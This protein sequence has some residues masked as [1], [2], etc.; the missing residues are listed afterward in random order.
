MSAPPG[1]EN[2]S[3]GRPLSPS[4]I[5][6]PR[7]SNGWDG[8]QRVGPK[9]A[10]LANPEALSDPDYSDEDAP[11]V[12]QIKADEDLLEDYPLDTEDIDLVHC[13]IMSMPDLH[14]ER[15]TK[16]QR[17]C[18]RQNQ[19]SDV[20]LPAELGEN[21]QELDLYDNVIAHI[22]G[23]DA[24]K[25][26][27]T[28][29]LSFNKIKHIKNLS[30]LKQLKELYFV[31]NKIAKIEG[32]D[33]LDSI[34]MIELAANRIREIEGLQAQAH[35]LEE[36]WLGRNKVVEMRNLDHLRNL[37]LLDV[38]SNRLTTMAG[39]T[40]L[41]NLEELYLSHNAITHI[42]GLENNT[43][44]RVLDISN[45]RISKLEKLG[46]LPELEEF[47][48]GSN[49]ISSFQDVEKELKDKKKL[50]TV[51][52]EMNPLQLMGPAVYRNK[53]RL[54]LPQVQQIDATYVKV[55]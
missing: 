6:K 29:D 52:F 10:I 3:T 39:L 8:K 37:R 55:S 30:M 51:Y 50:Q 35:S 26:L 34:R 11:P 27:H 24:M 7:D 54:A 4:S 18:L 12:D 42:S 43:K 31:Q 25:E 46:A 15:F 23:F 40:N 33:Q 47:W 21:L 17:I 5:R 13:R 44:L 2:N 1:E 49:Q 48:A 19:I 16:A 53:V 38:K 9:N 22:R 28:L 20:V 36:L 45:N 14:L 32:L 41:T